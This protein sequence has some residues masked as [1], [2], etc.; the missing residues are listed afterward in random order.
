MRFF[1]VDRVDELR[2]G[3]LARGVKN[4]SLT[5]D[6]FQDHFPEHPVFP[7]TLLIEALAQL[8]GFLAECSFHQ[9]ST[10]TRR[11]VLTQI[12]KAKLH[13]PC[14]PGDQ[15]E[16]VSRLASQLEGAAQLE[17]EA[18]VRGERAA[19]ATLTFRL[20]KVDSE[21]VH[22]QRRALYRLWTSELNLPFAIR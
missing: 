6:L 21:Q 2:P 12:D 11:A 14:R 9:D 15:I 16:L 4:L 8:S 7:G 10:E 22:E 20:L 13:L 19:S 17:T 5:E 18:L 1:L 3:E